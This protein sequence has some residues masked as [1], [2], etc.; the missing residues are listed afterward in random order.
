MIL[1]HCNVISQKDVEG[2]IEAL[3]T[4]KPYRLITPG[5]IYK[6]LGKSGRCCGCFPNVSAL[7]AKAN[8]R[9]TETDEV[10]EER[11]RQ[12]EPQARSNFSDAIHRKTA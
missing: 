12:L 11:K 4:E 5:L 10:G 6:T 8:A 7:I 3:L 1:C 9:I 2:A